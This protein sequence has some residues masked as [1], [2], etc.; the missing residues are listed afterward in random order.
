MSIHQLFFFKSL[1]KLVKI[2]N[3]EEGP[4]RPAAQR[5]QQQQRLLL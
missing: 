5:V 1:L 3:Y 2:Q 4:A